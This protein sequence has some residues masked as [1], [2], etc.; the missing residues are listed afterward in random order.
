MPL[1]EGIRSILFSLPT[2]CDAAPETIPN[3][4]NDGG[5]AFRLHE[6][7]WRQME[8]IPAAA[9]AQVDRE[10]AKVEAFKRANGTG[11]GCKSVYLRK[12]RPDG[13]YP[14]GVS[15]GR[16]D[17]I[18]HDP[19]ERLRIGTIGT[20]QRA[21]IVKG[22]FACLPAGLKNREHCRAFFPSATSAIFA[23]WMGVP[24]TSSPDPLNF[25]VKAKPRANASSQSVSL[26]A[27]MSADKRNP[28]ARQPETSACHKQISSANL[29]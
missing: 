3:P 2:I 6:D 13:L 21:Q 17:S 23:L 25:A 24:A 9:R 8:F 27:E 12:E 26:S 11:S 29:R 14:G 16:I 4:G 10:L 7:N 20:P 28:D 1:P 5:E 18:P 15:Y 22:G 19:I